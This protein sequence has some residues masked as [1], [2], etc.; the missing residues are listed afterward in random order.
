RCSTSIEARRSRRAIAVWPGTARTAIR[1]GPYARRTWSRS[2][3]G[4][5]RRWRMSLGYD[6][7]R[8]D[9]PV[10]DQLETILRHVA[11]ELA[12]WRR[13]G[14]WTGSSGG[15]R[16]GP[17]STKK[18]AVKVMI[19]GEEYTVR[20]DLPPEYTR[21]VAAYVDQALKKVLSQGPIVETH[22]AAILAALDITNELFQA[23]K[24][25]REVAAR[26]AALADDLAK[27]L[28]P[29]KRKAVVG[30]L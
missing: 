28:P 1:F 2:R 9:A 15:S 30:Q 22:K 7:E 12:L 18:Q 26:L 20:S 23:K 4:V 27:L 3:S 14:E 21:E 19:G 10:L 25:E 11:D 5:L 17:V 8:S 6:G 24:G 29:G 16:G 13:G